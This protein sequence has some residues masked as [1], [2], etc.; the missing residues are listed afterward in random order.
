MN[1]KSMHLA[2]RVFSDTY[3]YVRADRADSPSHSEQK[4]A[5]AN[6]MLNLLEIK[7][8]VKGQPS[9][10]RPLILVGNHISYLDIVT[11]FAAFP[12]VSF[13]A[14]EELANWP[15]FGMGAKK[16]GTI[17]VK[18]GNATA[19]NAAKDAIRL[20]L[21]NE[22]K[23]VCIFPSGTTCLDESKLWK[24][25]AFRLAQE[26]GVPLQV[27]RLRYHPLRKAAYIDKD[28]FPV[29]LLGLCQRNP[30]V[31]ASLEF[32]PPTKI[33]NAELDCVHWHHWASLRE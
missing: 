26:T 8:T 20:A 19:Q 23:C 7:L 33:H 16:A 30:P 29:H 22:R 1:I 15:I 21:E 2:L 25:G 32:A 3:K 14:K 31:V 18:R 6:E 5:W 24:Y 28:F 11:L 12:D 9:K 13:V 17:F 4:Q 10:A 27:F